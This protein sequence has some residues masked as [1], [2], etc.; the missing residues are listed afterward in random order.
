MLQIT[1]SK[2]AALIIALALLL[3]IPGVAVADHIFTDVGHADTHTPGIEWV[4]DAGVTA[5]CGDGT[6][7]CPNDNVTRAQMGTFM[8]RLSGNCGVAPSVNAATAADSDLLDGI[9]STGFLGSTAK[10]ADAD[11][12]DGYDANSM[13]RF[14]GDSVDSDVIKVHGGTAASVTMTAPGPGYLIISASSNLFNFGGTDLFTC[15]ILVN[16]SEILA[17]GRDI[18]LSI[19]NEQNCSTDAHYEVYAA[20]DYTVDFDYSGVNPGTIVGRTVL[21][22]LFVPFGPTGNIPTMP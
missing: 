11:K 17:S 4:A 21:N 16:G 7:Y 14:A 12:V 18:E 2:R 20:G 19:T 9:D 3:V 8:C 15:R 5:G 10:A 6:A 22:V 13:I 1:I